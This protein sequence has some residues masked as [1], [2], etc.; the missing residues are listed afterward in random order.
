MQGYEFFFA[1]GERIIYVE[2]IHRTRLMW[3]KD[4]GKIYRKI[5]ILYNSS[6][7]KPEKIPLA[8]G[9]LFVPIACASFFR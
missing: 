3:D 5:T 4:R 2:G 7:N 1:A 9:R 6:N 8:G